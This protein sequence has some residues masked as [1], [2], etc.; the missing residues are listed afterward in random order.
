MSTNIAYVPQAIEA[1]WQQ[2]WED[3]HIYR[4]QVDWN[5]PKHYAVTM[6]PYPSGDLHIGHWFAMTPSDARARYMRMKGYN[7]LFPMG[8][9]AFGLPA[10]QAAIS[11]N[12]HPW[13]W[14]FANIERMRGQMKSMGNMFD[15]EREMISA[16]PEYYRWTEWFFKQFYE[17]DLAYRGEALVNWSDALQ[18]VL[19]NEQVIDGKDERLGQ[20]VIQKMMT[21]WFFRYTRY[22]EEM[23]D[24]SKIDWQESVVNS[25]TNWIG[26]SVGAKVTF[27]TENGDPLVVFTTRPDTLWGATFMVLAPEHPLVDKI[28]TPAQQEAVNAYKAQTAKATEIERL[29]EDRQKTGVFTGGYAINPVNNALIPI[30]IADYVMVNYGTGAIM[31]VPGGDVRDFAFARQ[32][33]LPVIAVVQPEGETFDGATMTEGYGG[34]GVIINSDWLNGAISNGEKGRKN[35]AIAKMIDWLVK[36]GIGQEN[37][38]YRLRDWLISRQRYWGSPIPVV[39]DP[40]GNIHLVPDDELPVELPQDVEFKPTGRSPLTYHEP[41]FNYKDGW[42]RET[43]T[44][45]TFMCSSWYWYR[46]LSPHETTAP[47]NAEEAAYWL[48]V[49]TYTGGSEHATM[50]LLYSRWFAKSMRDLGMFDDATEIARAHGRE[51]DDL[52]G[53]PFI[54]YRSQGQVL[55]AKRLGDYVVAQGKH[56][57]NK[58]IASSI[59]VIAPIDAPNDS[60]DIVHGELM[61]RVE[62][63]LFVGET[64]QIVEALP[65]ASIEIPSIEGT[66]NVNQ[67]KH[68]LD[69]QRMSKSKGNVVNPDE[70]VKKYGSDTVRAHL[71]FAY[72]WKIG[73]PWDEAN[74]SGV[75]R[76]LNDVWNMITQYTPV[77]GDPAIERNTERK[78]HQIIDKLGNS[79]EKFSFNTAVAALMEFRNEWKSAIRT[80]GLGESMFKEIAHI[81]LR[82]MAPIT[83]HITEE[84]WAYLGFGFS[85]HQQAFPIADPEKAK[86]DTVE[87]VVMINGKPRTTVWVSPT[88]EQAEAEQVA[89]ADETVQ[90]ILNGSAPKRVVYI[91]PRGGQE[92]KVNIVL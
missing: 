8:F 22:A 75:T 27:K 66:N 73:G 20:P 1:K 60:P 68:H 86:D 61:K 13:K 53:E 42:R 52:F 48:P 17:N 51:D 67:L 55:G 64:M 6:L 76:W 46:Y 38:N 10:E 74:V 36:K 89:L 37:I 9:D 26:K 14:T 82:L 54:Q 85:I 3:Q 28:T 35:P 56:E 11:R 63:T 71:M 16:V 25:Q 84:L 49:D 90:K 59:K 29:S 80:N 19:A 57:G 18:T 31:A 41:F 72:D 40:Q 83:P 43:D 15:W 87:L 77:Q 32:F 2:Q 91:A 33:N 62:N 34:A 69:I 47:F 70:L 12:I 30:W 39:Y 7:V 44:M 4:S 65:S 58:F 50:H 45:D 81:Y 23:L 78:L 88:I 79:I 92:P 21:Q 5:K 24:F